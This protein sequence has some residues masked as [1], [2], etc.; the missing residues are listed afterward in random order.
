MGARQVGKTTLSK[1]LA[2]EWQ[3]PSHHFD[4]EDPDDQARLGDPSFVLRELRG[5]V[6][7]DAVQVHPD[8]F[9]LLRVLTDRPDTPTRFLHI[10]GAALELLKAT[11]ET[12][13]GRVTLHQL[14]GL[15]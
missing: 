14:H 15:E 13:A 9:P 4:M 5:L 8:L 1:Q 12:M 7:L 2:K 11:A 6:V 10:G 3:G